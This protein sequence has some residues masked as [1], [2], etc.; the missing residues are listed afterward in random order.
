MSIARLLRLGRARGDVEIGEELESHLK[1]AIEERIARGESRADAEANARREFGNV[2]HVQEVAREMSGSLWLERF[3]QDARFGLRMLRRA[4]GF[5]IVAILCLTLGI[6]ANAVVGGWIEGILFRPYPGVANEDRLVHV[7][8][9]A[10]GDPEFTDLSFPDFSDLE[11]ESKFCDAFIVSKIIGTTL[12]AGDRAERV[13][14]LMVSP[15]YFE[16]L[17]VRPVLGRGFA[18]DEGTGWNAHPVTVI[19]YREWQDRFHGDPAIIGRTQ[20][21]NGVTHVIV[22][23]A[24]EGFI[25]TFVGYSMQFYV[26]TS[27]QAAFDPS[28]YKLED[29]DARWIEGFALL[30]R[31]ATLDQ[32][33]SEVSAAAARLAST[34]PDQDRGRGV[35]LLP[36]WRGTFDGAQ[37]LMPT[38]R[39]GL[40]VA[41]FVLLIA[42]ANV[43]NLLLVRSFVRRH[44]ITV[45]L[46][47]G[48]GRM[49]LIRQLFTEAL[50]LSAIATG[51]AALLAYWLR[52]SLALFFPSSAGVVYTFRGDFDWRVCV[53]SAMIGIMSVVVFAAVPAL[54]SSRADLSGALKSDSRSSSGQRDRSRLRAALVVFQVAL[55]FVLLVAAGLVLQSLQSISDASPGFSTDGVLATSLN[56]FAAGYDSSRAKTFDD[57]LVQR[58][59]SIGGVDTV[60]I[61]RSL[62]FSTR[63]YDSGPIA[64]DGFVPN[65]DEQPTARYNS[66]SP[67]YFATLGIDLRSG[68]D[69]T[70]GDDES[71]EPVAIVSETM[72]DEFWRG[73]S[74]IGKR[75]QAGGRWRRIVGV[76][77]NVKF[78]SLLDAPRALFYLPLRQNFSTQG[79]IFIRTRQTPDALRRSLAREIRALDPRVAPYEVLTLREQVRRATSAQRIAVT[80]LGMFGALAMLLAGIGLYGTMAYAVSQRTRELGLR[81]ALGAA[82]SVLL[83]LIISQGLRLTAMGII[84]GGVAAFASTRLIAYMLYRVSPRDPRA[85]ISALVVMVL[86]ALLACVAPAWRAA[87]TDPV[88]ALR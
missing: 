69:F 67:G 51:C 34:Y 1:M 33:Q 52:N 50:L 29:R 58:I 11:R 31:G 39:I 87:R 49:R 37:N 7:A 59:R 27:M 55:S 64:V 68:R 18:P 84:V 42:C 22:G 83:R 43:A 56:L 74:P 77:N 9:T 48:A 72:V 53:L 80:L 23:V 70:T 62:P 26:P 60:A 81:T 66:V 2:G 76:A 36:L 73:E 14:G 45:R 44:E 8:G 35:R 75:L 13:T 6:G 3:A 46:S 88:T 79:A 28:G 54:Q 5:S 24:P 63:P 17:G 12:S 47:L 85:F 30:K 86:A 20:Q 10:R 19:S 41:V 82:P 61:A 71:S 25:G 65:A 21:Y 40:A 4:P 38:L 78:E 32:A 16:A 15:N 57:R